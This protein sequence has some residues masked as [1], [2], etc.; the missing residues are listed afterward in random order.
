MRTEVRRLSPILDL[1]DANTEGFEPLPTGKY[2]AEIFEITMDE[3]Q[4]PE[5]KVPK[6][7]PLM[8]VQ[9]KVVEEPYENRRLFQQ[10]VI[11]PPDYP[12]DKRAWMLCMLA[13]FFIA[14]GEDEA[15]VK[16]SNFDPD[17]DDYKGRRV[18]VTVAQR[19]YE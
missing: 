8:K 1:S 10:Y 3:T 18:T 14:T 5:G 7:T 6:G 11:P 12:K 4:N 19:T 17:L 15:T 13:N 2:Q 9:Y 16:S